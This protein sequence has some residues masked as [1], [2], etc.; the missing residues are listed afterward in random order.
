[1]SRHLLFKN[2]AGGQRGDDVLQTWAWRRLFHEDGLAKQGVSATYSEEEHAKG[3][4][5]HH[6]AGTV[7]R[8]PH[9]LAA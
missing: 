4:L 5:R 7:E 6:V 3:E 8:F 9:L 2:R 1:M